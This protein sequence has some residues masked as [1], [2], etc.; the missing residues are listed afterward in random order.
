[1]MQRRGLIKIAQDR[2]RRLACFRIL[3]CILQCA[4]VIQGAQ[5][6]ANAV[7]T[8]FQHSQRLIEIG[9]SSKQGVMH[10]FPFYLIC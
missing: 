3:A 2:F 4:E 9:R 6:F 8:V 10:G 1:M 5:L 7:V